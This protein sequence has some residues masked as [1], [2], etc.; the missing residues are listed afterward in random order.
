MKMFMC[1][2]VVML[3]NSCA[4]PTHEQ[5]CCDYVSNETLV[6][7]YYDKKDNGGKFYFL[8]EYGDKCELIKYSYKVDIWDTAT[9]FRMDNKSKEKYWNYFSANFLN[10]SNDD[11]IEVLDKIISR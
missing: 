9:S 6:L 3:F 5:V 8:R 7:H 4:T 10:M 2:L 1:F 11:K